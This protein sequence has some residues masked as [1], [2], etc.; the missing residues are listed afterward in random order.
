M[1]YNQA[2]TRARSLRGWSQATVAEKLGT[3]RK[4]VSR[5]E[6][7]E[8]LPSPYFR[9]RLCQLFECDT[10]ALNLLSPSASGYN[11]DIN[12]DM[13]KSLPP[14]GSSSLLANA[15]RLVGREALLQ[16]L[17]PQIQPGS[18]LA[19]TGLP[20][21]GKTKLL[22]TL[23]QHP[24]IQERFP[25]GVIWVRLGPTPDLPRCFSGVAR[26][27]GIS[28]LVQ[29]PEASDADRWQLLRK[30]INMR[31]L[32]I[33]LDDVWDVEVV[34]PFLTES[35]L[36]SYVLTTRQPS[37]ASALASQELCVVQPLSFEASYQ[38]LTTLVP[39]V[40]IISETHLQR[41]T[42]A[43]G[44]L[45]LAIMLIGKYLA[46]HS[47]RG[48]LRRVEMALNQLN[49]LEYRLHLN[50]PLPPVTYLRAQSD[51]NIRSLEATISIS[52]RRLPPVAQTVLRALSVL[53]KAP[54]FFSEEAAI[55]V[56]ATEQEMLDLLVDAGLI[57]PSENHCYQ[58]HRV[59]A[60][61]AWYHLEEKTVPQMRLVEYINKMCVDHSTDVAL[62]ERE[63]STFVVGIETAEAL[64]MYDTLTRGVLT[65][66]PYMR[67]RGL[68][69]TKATLPNF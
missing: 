59:V 53:P 35:S 40:E 23:S 49:D 63:Y 60:D 21:V 5:W 34:H 9:E 37:I 43:T 48:Q 28:S 50:V 65:L 6:C 26:A 32:L 20:G 30:I 11:R 10:E 69:Q 64:Q 29:E 4:N 31:H 54:D 67:M 42:M 45:P 41:V 61:Y 66:I 52:D 68:L 13:T 2:L 33:V 44:G 27:L 36:V 56:G 46:S 14:A 17:L 1:T 16:S 55:A 8:T 18:I 24:Q 47:Y 12:V 39:Q 51:E 7:G 25:D 62:L 3:S 38:I 22:E 15:Q 57:E 19:L 58:L